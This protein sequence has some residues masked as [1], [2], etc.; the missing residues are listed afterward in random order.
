M[1][2]ELFNQTSLESRLGKKM[3]KRYM[4]VLG[5]D[6]QSSFSL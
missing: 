2:E 3:V 5:P 4:N 1:T 6:T